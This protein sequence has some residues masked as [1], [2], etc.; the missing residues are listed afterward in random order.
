MAWFKRWRH[1]TLF[2]IS[3]ALSGLVAAGLLLLA[4]RPR[5]FDVTIIGTWEG[6]SAPSLPMGG[7]AVAIV[8]I[9]YMLVVPGRPRM[10]AKC[11]GPVVLILAA[12]LRIYLGIDHFTDAL[13]GILLGVSIPVAIFRAFAPNDVFPC[14]TARMGRRR[15]SMSQAGAARRSGSPAGAARPGGPRA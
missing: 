3:V 11:V 13:F 6:Y 2:L 1:L 14:I 8:G 7:L 9:V 4:S 12:L 10:Y 15:T 5:P